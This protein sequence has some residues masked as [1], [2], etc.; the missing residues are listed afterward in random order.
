VTEVKVVFSG[1]NRG[2]VR[3]AEGTAAGGFAAGDDEAWLELWRRHELW[4]PPADE[5]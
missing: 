1:D 4:R 3:A 2:A 5:A